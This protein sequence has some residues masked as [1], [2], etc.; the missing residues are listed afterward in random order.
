MSLRIK[1]KYVL[2]VVLYGYSL[3]EIDVGQSL[4]SIY[5]SHSWLFIDGSCTA[6]DCHYQNQQA[7]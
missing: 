7:E 6:Q 1:Y 5:N 2:A 3:G 4:G